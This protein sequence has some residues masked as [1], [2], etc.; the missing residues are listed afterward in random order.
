MIPLLRELVTALAGTPATFKPDALWA[1]IAGLAATT[2]TE[3]NPATG[4]NYFAQDGATYPTYGTASFPSSF[5]DATAN[6]TWHFWQGWNT[7]TG[8][9]MARVSVRN[10][11]TGVWAGPYTASRDTEVDDDHGAPAAV[12]DADGYVHVFG[13][14]HNG[15]AEWA[16]TTTARDPRF[17]T[18]RSSPYAGGYPHPVCIGSKVYVFHRSGALSQ[19][20]LAEATM[21]G[22]AG[23]F[24]DRNI[25]SLTSLRWYSG[26]F[27]V[28]GND[29]HIVATAASATDTERRDVYYLIYN[30]ATEA[31]RNYSNSVSVAKASQPL[32]QATLDASFRLRDQTTAGRY[33][34]GVPSMSRAANGD[35]TFIYFDGAAASGVTFNV[36]VFSIVGGVLGSDA[37]IGTAT[38]ALRVWNSYIVADPA[39]GNLRALWTDG[40]R[41]DDTLKT[42]SFNGS[43]SA[44]TDFVTKER[45]FNISDPSIVKGGKT[46]HL[47]TYNEVSG[48]STSEQQ[49]RVYAVGFDG[50]A[51]K[52]ATGQT[53]TPQLPS[54][55]TFT[56]SPNQSQSTTVLSNTATISGL[57]ETTPIS[58]SA[59]NGT[60]AEYRINGGSWTSAAG[61]VSNGDTLQLH[62]TTPASAISG[63]ITIQFGNYGG[64]VA[65][66]TWDTTV[67][68]SGETVIAAVES[69]SGAAMTDATGKRTA[70]KALIDGFIADGDWA[71]FDYAAFR[72]VPTQTHA[73]C[74]FVGTHDATITGSLTFTADRGFTGGVSGTNYL[75]GTFNPTTHGVNYTQN[76]AGVLFWDRNGITSGTSEN[77]MILPLGA[78]GA[79]VQDSL[80]QNSSNA[81]AGAVNFAATTGRQ[82]GSGGANTASMK[83][84]VRT[85][86]N[87]MT[88]YIGAT[89][90]GTAATASTGIPNGVLSTHT[91][92]RQLIIEIIGAGWSA[93]AITRINGRIATW[94][95]AIGA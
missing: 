52:R 65:T 89:A 71:T 26:N 79:T 46:T 57:A 13:G 25:T 61:F 21:S 92:A 1:Q 17:W 87:L 70:L 62:V 93:A 90:S 35:M 88:F 27:I 15:A 23:T 63:S 94:K 86:S 68:V 39:T 10:H 30:V 55:V 41:E 43:W 83:A 29:V 34:G 50:T 28:D 91:S 80:G 36:N 73:L 44:V 59:T 84:A 2:S 4:T 81:I 82:V 16:T 60:A 9:R 40:G 75:L 53:F 18:Q 22:G 47:I 32:N 64:D 56:A 19:L 11:S 45:S 48:D 85:A 12:I 49:L 42:A 76:S 67:L 7:N 33:S 37:T 3:T 31:V 54:T 51:I 77:S 69:R 8:S 66:W 95:T 5:Y 14:T 78:S 38:S 24:T 20:S 74:D 6:K 58:L 72:A